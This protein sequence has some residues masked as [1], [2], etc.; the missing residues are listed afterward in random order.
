MT[1]TT[2]SS[3]EFQRST[4]KAQKAARSGPVFI[5]SRGRTTHVLLS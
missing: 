1:I 5:T 3:R 4:S 2:L